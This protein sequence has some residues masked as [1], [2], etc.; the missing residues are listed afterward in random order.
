MNDQQVITSFIVSLQIFDAHTD[1][2]I[3]V[4]FFIINVFWNKFPSYS[5]LHHIIL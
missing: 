4:F 1:E 3:W 2:L 5:H